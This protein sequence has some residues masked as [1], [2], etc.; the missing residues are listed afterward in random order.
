MWVADDGDALT[1]FVVGVGN[2]AAR[3]QHCMSCVIG[4]LQKAVGQRLGARLMTQLEDWAR[5]HGFTRIELTVMAHNDRAKRLYLGQ[6]FEV[7]GRRGVAFNRWGIHDEL[8]MA[9][10]LNA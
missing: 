3:N 7:E 6:G 10:L 2:M 8:Y 9:K 1:G 5:A 4:I